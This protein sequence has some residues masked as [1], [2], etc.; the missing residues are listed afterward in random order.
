MEEW[1]E[2]LSLENHFNQTNKI[3]RSEHSENSHQTGISP[4]NH[5]QKTNVRRDEQM[6]WQC[7]EGSSHSEHVSKEA[8]FGIAFQNSTRG[9]SINILE[10]EESW[11]IQFGNKF[12]NRKAGITRSITFSCITLT[13]KTIFPQHWAQARLKTL[14]ASLL[15]NLSM[16]S[17]SGFRN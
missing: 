11:C 17:L 7:S 6:N 9:L 3:N 5:T 14:A 2:T 15:V 13:K 10:K 12:T 16:Q 4:H 8:N 1:T